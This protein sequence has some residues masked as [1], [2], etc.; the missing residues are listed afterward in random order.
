MKGLSVR[1]IHQMATVRRRVVMVGVLMT[2]MMAATGTSAEAD[3]VSDLLAQ[4]QRILATASLG[5][6]LKVV[7]TSRTTDAPSITTAIAGSATGALKLIT[8]ALK[9]PSTIGVD[10]VHTVRMAATNDTFRSRQWALKRFGAEKVWKK[11]T[12]RGVLVAVIDTG[13]R[14]G[15]PDL[16]GRVVKGKD[17]VRPGTSAQDE[18]GHGTHVAGVIA[19]VANNKRGIAG[20]AH[21]ARILPVRVLDATGEGSSDDVAKGIIWAVDAGADVINLS[22]GSSRADTAQ[23]E[24]IAYAVSKNVVVV[25]A[26]GNE[27]CRRGGGLLGGSLLDLGGP[28]GSF[29]AEYPRVLGVGA[30]NPDGTMA[31][32]SNCGSYVDVVAPGTNIISTVSSRPDPS[33]GCQGA[34]GY[35]YLSGTSMATSYVSAAAALKIQQL[36]KGWKQIRVRGLIQDTASDIG[37]SGRDDLSGHGILHPSRLLARR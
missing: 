3:P 31:D 27:G 32:Y 6:P 15:H 14:A 10:M 22:L 2:T 1:V 21:S 33:L 36:G 9:D 30:I 28:D 7:V 12:G 23:E 19:A 5:E 13:V 25:A 29:P 8:S 16:R 35:C 17:F 37:A 4:A 11:S 34:S 26:A 24:A 20:L 18:N